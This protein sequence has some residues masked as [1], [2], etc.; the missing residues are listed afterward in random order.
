MPVPPPPTGDLAPSPAAHWDP[1]PSWPEPWSGPTPP[2]PATSSPSWLA[3]PGGAL[4]RPVGGTVATALPSAPLEHH[5]LLR[6][7]RARWWRP[8]VSLLLLLGL[9]G[10]VWT[11]IFLGGDLVHAALSDQPFD[12]ALA[13]GVDLDGFGP[14]AQLVTDLTLA[15]LIPVVLVATRVVHHVRPGFVSSVTGRL[16]WRWLLRCLLA[17]LPV[18]VVYLG[19][20]FVLDPPASGRPEPW[21]LLLVLAL[22]VTPFQAAGEEYLFRGWLVQDVA[23]WFAHPGV[24]WGV[25][26]VVSAGLF[27]LVHGSLDP[28][29]LLDIAALGVAACALNRRPGGLEAGIALHVVN[30]VLLG[31]ATTTVGG[32]EESFVSADSSGSPVALLTSLVVLTLAALLVLRAARRAGVERRA[33][34]AGGP[35]LAPAVL[36]G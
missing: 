21:P 23:V 20:G 7:P 3:S 26:T 24:A 1:V 6:G 11:A 8:L 17:V 5:Q 32:Y 12:D 16:R 4:S 18:W 14:G 19:L 10:V 29:V 9:V 27:A 13:A 28:W 36:P 15:A 33:R 31:I 34:P 2:V 35:P 25:S 22:V 30:N